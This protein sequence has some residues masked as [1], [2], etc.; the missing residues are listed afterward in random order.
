MEASA[1]QMA[2]GNMGDVTFWCLPAGDFIDPAG[3]LSAPPLNAVV[4]QIIKGQLEYAGEFSQCTF[5][6]DFKSPVPQGAQF[7][8]KDNS[9][10]IPFLA[11]KLS[12]DPAN[13][14]KGYAV[15]MHGMITAPPAWEILF[16]FSVTSPSS[17]AV[18]TSPAHY[19]RG[20]RA[21]VC[22]TGLK[23]NPVT[24]ACPAWQDTHPSDPGYTPPA[25]ETNT[26]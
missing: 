3:Y 7:E 8:A 18:W 19:D 26:E 10:S 22:W 6:Y 11:V 2:V 4:G 5:V 16:Q 14:N 25:P 17:S 24:L 23:P 21:P 1:S 15:L 20:W 9:S 12:P 13:P